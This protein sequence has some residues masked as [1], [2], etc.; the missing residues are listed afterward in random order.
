MKCYDIC[1]CTPNVGLPD[2]HPLQWLKQV[3]YTKLYFEHLYLKR[4]QIVN[5]RVEFVHNYKKF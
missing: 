4:H 3:E 5:L 1:N 2:C